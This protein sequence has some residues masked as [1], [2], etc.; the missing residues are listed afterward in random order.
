MT[1][2]RIICEPVADFQKQDRAGQDDNK[3]DPGHGRGVAHV[4]LRE[5]LLVEVQGVEQGR[6]DRAARAAAD[7]DVAGLQVDLNPVS[8]TTLSTI[9]VVI[10]AI[11]L[12]W[13][14]LGLS[15]VFA[16][17]AAKTLPENGF[18]IVS[19]HRGAG[20]EGTQPLTRDTQQAAE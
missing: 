13:G 18:G 8:G 20:P 10:S 12:V 3:K 5:G 7:D 15:K 19:G 14:V 4:E 1:S 2:P 11:G 6:I 9:S 16:R 17:R